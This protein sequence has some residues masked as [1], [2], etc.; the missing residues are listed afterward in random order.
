MAGLFEKD[1]RLILQRKRI[2]AIFLFIMIV[3][4]IS[5]GGVMVIS[6][7][8]MLFGIFTITIQSYDDYENSIPFLL[9][10]P[11]TRKDYVKEKFLF[12][13][14]GLLVGWVISILIGLI[15]ELFQGNSF[16]FFSEWR[17]CLAVFFLFFAFIS[18]MIPIQLK[19][20]AERSR[21]IVMIIGGGIF[22]IA[23]VGLMIAGKLGIEPSVPTAISSLPNG[24]VLAGFIFISIC[25]SLGMYYWSLKVMEKK[26][27]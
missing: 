20:D 15:V 23:A 12:C 2:Y 3:M 8:T 25:L 27:Y 22:G 14:G 24:A 9:T 21:V 16:V 18:I 6:Y 1:I 7:G 17:E 4:S 13:G 26:E 11:V 5:S 10:L 19:Y